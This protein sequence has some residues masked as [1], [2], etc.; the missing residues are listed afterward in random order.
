[1]VSVASSQPA[2]QSRRD[3]GIGCGCRGRAAED[4]IECSLYGK[5][6]HVEDLEMSLTRL[7]FHS[8]LKSPWAAPVFMVPLQRDREGD[9]GTHPPRFISRSQDVAFSAA[10]ALHGAWRR[11]SEDSNEKPRAEPDTARPR[12][13]AFDALGA[14]Q[15]GH[16]N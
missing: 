6:I 1:M 13:R 4:P 10:G 8:F 5:S 3:R 16:R 9:H 2:I 11:S 7:H 15:E 14:R 12:S